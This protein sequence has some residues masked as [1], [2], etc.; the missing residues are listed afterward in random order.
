MVVEEPKKHWIEAAEDRMREDEKK[1]LDELKEKQALPATEASI[2]YAAIARTGVQV[3]HKPESFDDKLIHSYVQSGY[4]PDVMITSA[5]PFIMDKDIAWMMEDSKVAQ[6]Q[7]AEYEKGKPELKHREGET[8]SIFTQDEANEALYYELEDAT[9]QDEWNEYWQ[10]V[11]EQWR[12]Y[13][14]GRAIIESRILTDDDILAWKVMTPFCASLP[15]K[16]LEAWMAGKEAGSRATHAV[17][18]IG[19][20]VTGQKSLNEDGV[21]SRGIRDKIKHAFRR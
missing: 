3:L 7:L 10:A 17:A 2:E 11:L 19:S 20:V 4:E 21:V 16:L 15:E 14:F 1:R 13:D 6:K 8:P 12:T 5:I 18:N 9:G